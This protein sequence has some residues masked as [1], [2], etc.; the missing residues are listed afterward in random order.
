MNTPQQAAPTEQ[1]SGNGVTITTEKR[2]DTFDSNLAALQEEIR[3]ESR[4]QPVSESDDSSVAPPAGAPDSLAASDEQRA[5][6]RRARLAQLQARERARVEE[7]ANAR[8]A[9][10]LRQRL[11]AAE[12]RATEAETAMQARIERAA[13]RDP[14]AAL[15]ILESEGLPADKLADAIRMRFTD[16]EMAATHAAKRAVDPEIAALKQVIA[17]RDAQ[18]QDFLARQ[19]E[20]ERAEHEQRETQAFLHGVAQS[21]GLS[22][23]FLE[24]EGPEPFLNIARK[25]AAMLPD[26]AGPQAL[27][28]QIEE[29][30][31]T[32]GRAIAQQLAN[33]YGLIPSNGQPSPPKA[34]AAKAPPTTVTNQIAQERA[35]VVTESELWRLP[36]DERVAYLRKSMM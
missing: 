14:M 32:R 11:E 10:E 33:I 22:A 15:Q 9:T 26:H 31:E 19:Q 28:D 34:A 16:P 36:Y 17:E 30:L 23:R 4:S 7:H 25:A 27:H 24:A 2:G 29:L 3:H 13:L 21:G 1:A 8:T 18:L 5:T 35:S 12:R 6:D 20:R